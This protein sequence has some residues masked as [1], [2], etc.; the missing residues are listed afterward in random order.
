MLYP[1]E[2]RD[3]YTLYTQKFGLYQPVVMSRMRFFKRFS[4]SK[5]QRKIFLGTIFLFASKIICGVDL[6]NVGIMSS[7]NI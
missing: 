5:D 3:L 1:A 6:L 4:Y 7:M 2:L